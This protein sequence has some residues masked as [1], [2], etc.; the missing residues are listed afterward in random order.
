MIEM[1]KLFKD[2]GEKKMEL[3]IGKKIATH[4]PGHGNFAGTV[5]SYD[6]WFHVKYDDDDEQDMDLK[7]VQQ[8]IDLY[9]EH[10]TWR[11]LFHY[12]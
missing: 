11:T 12:S 6:G 10:F 3:Y 7:E 2:V 9:N 1:I 4:F 5:E 8:G